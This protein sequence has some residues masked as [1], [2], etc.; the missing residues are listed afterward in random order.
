MMSLSSKSTLHASPA[1]QTAIDFLPFAFEHRQ[2]L[3]LDEQYDHIQ[4][5]KRGIINQ[6]DI[7]RLVLEAAS[8]I[9]LW[10]NLLEEHFVCYACSSEIEVLSGPFPKGAG[11]LGGLKN[12][13]ELVLPLYKLNSPSIPY[14][15][16]SARVRSFYASKI[17]SF[18]YQSNPLPALLCID[19][20]QETQFNSSRRELL[21]RCCAQIYAAYDQ[22]SNYLYVNYERQTLQQVFN[23]LQTLNGS[24]DSESVFAAV[25]KAISFIVKADLVMIGSIVGGIL[26]LDYVSLE[27]LGAHV[28]QHFPLEDSVAGQ[29]VKYKRPMPDSAR[30]P[31]RAQLING[32]YSLPECGSHAVFPLFQDEGPVTGVL[33]I[34][35]FEPNPLLR[36]RRELLEM[37]CT[38]LAIKLDLAAA[39]DK[40]N[41]ISMQDSLTGVANRRAFERGLAAMHERMLRS[42]TSYSLILCDIDH[43]KQVNDSYGHPFGDQVIIQV[44]R[45]LNNVVRA[46]DLAA[47]V[48]GE[49]FA[50]L[51]EGTGRKGAYEVAERLRENVEK[52][53]LL[54]EQKPVRV[55]IS[56]GI[57]TFSENTQDRNRLFSHADQ[58]LYQAKN[59]GRNCSVLW[60]PELETS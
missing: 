40:I 28:K 11:I 47:R 48:G 29:V 58:A 44:A 36:S 60:T 8:V 31:Q 42:G 16:D 38:Q 27:E 26:R 22:T 55:T 25:E 24:L 13:D 33:I 43:F 30:L 59:Q 32:L 17:K 35:T 14:Y 20:A 41:R 50:I 53:R 9:L 39:H 1:D 6:L 49:E 52:L 23:S 57:A 56:I 5:F 19:F 4:Q 34:A 54:F 15:R 7:L 51:L 18:D 46:V 3:C 45:Q 10:E 2:G 12:R 21:A 37:V